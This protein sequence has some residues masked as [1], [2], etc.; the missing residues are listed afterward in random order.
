MPVAKSFKDW[1]KVTEV[2]SINGR[3]YIKVRNPKTGSVRQ[4]RHYS[5]NEYLKMYPEEKAEEAAVF[6][7]QKDLLGFQKG[8]I[9]IFKGD[10]YG[11][12]EWFQQSIARYAKF[13]GWYIVS[14]EEVPEDLPLGITPVRLPWETVGNDSGNLLPEATIQ[15]NIAPLLYEVSTSEYQGTI[16]QRIERT[17]TVTKVIDLENAF[18]SSTM[19]TMEDEDKNVYLWTTSARRWSE[20]TVKT[21]RGTVK[22]HNEFRNVK[23]TVL[24]RCTEVA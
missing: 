1:E 18:G 12:L 7:S 3:D 17:L 13:W 24:T 16:G 21:L 6:A 11:N 22:A 15:K 9:T 4:V 8:Y 10:T 5:Q 14:T 20:G 23:Q 2:Y 19:M